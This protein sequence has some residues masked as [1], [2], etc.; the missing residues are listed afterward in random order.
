MTNAQIAKLDEARIDI[1]VFIDDPTMPLDHLES[2]LAL[3]ESAMES[4]EEAAS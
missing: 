2:A 1:L 4:L 3:I